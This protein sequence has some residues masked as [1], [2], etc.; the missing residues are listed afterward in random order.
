[1]INKRI[2]KTFCY[3]RRKIQKFFFWKIKC[4]N[5]FIINS[6]IHK[7]TDNFIIHTVSYNIFSC[8]ICAKYKRSMGT[9]QNT[10]FTLFVRFMIICNKNRKSCF[11]NREFIF[12]GLRTFNYP[13]SKDLACVQNIIFISKFLVD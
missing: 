6:L 3:R 11:I 13:E 7:S 9:I 5:N 2:F 12:N 1:M 4:R 8:K 10:Y